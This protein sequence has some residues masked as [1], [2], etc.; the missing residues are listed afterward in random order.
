[1]IA[2]LNEI[3]GLPATTPVAEM[4]GVADKYSQTLFDRSAQGDLDA[5][6]KLIEL[7]VAYLTWA[8]AK[9]AHSHHATLQ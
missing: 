2:R 6:R 7:Q 1:M 8:Y 5:Q 4:V 3:I 9:H